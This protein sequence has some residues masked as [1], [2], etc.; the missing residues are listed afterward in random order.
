VTDPHLSAAQAT[1]AG[2][3][4]AATAL[5]VGELASAVLDLA[6]SP[7]LGVGGRFVDSFAASLKE[8]AV[9]LF[10]TNDKPALVIGTVVSTILLGAA[11][12]AAARRRRWAPWPVFSAF[13]VVGALAQTH[14]PRVSGAGPWVVALLSASAGIATL[15]VLLRAASAPTGDRPGAATSGTATGGTAV[16]GDLLVG[17]RRRFL[18]GA[19]T[20]AVGA[21]VMAA[22]GRAMS[23]VDVVA[24]AARQFRLPTPTRR[25]PVADAELGLVG[26]SPVITPT[27]DF[28]RIDTALS[29][30]QVDPSWWTL[31]IDG[32]VREPFELTFDELLALPSVEEPVTLQ[33]VSNE[34]GGSLVGTAR[35]QGVPL[36]HLLE[37]AGV[38]P[39]AEQVFSRSVDGW[40][41]GFPIEA[42]DDGRVALVA[43][44]MNGELLPVAHGFPARLVVSGLYGYVS[45]TKWVES[46]EL[47]TWEGED[48]YWVPRGWS[49]R[50]PA[51]LTSRID[52]PRHRSTVAAG[53]VTVAGVAWLPA[54]GIEAVEVSVDGGPWRS[55]ELAPAISEHTWVQWRQVID[56]AP[57]DHRLRV[58][59]VDA[60]GAVQT[61]TR[62]DPAPDGATGL[63]QVRV[64][65]VSS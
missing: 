41:S 54:T 25:R 48:G 57:G 33:C 23:R 62:T 39:E 22:A 42:V 3:L 29:S 64:Q 61:A 27:A 4:A 10:G 18:V 8:L 14:D 30:P 11:M 13:A 43:Y 5:A 63:H 20:A 58:R 59:A 28:Y 46:I 47:T 38:R 7:V 44:A 9:A 36:A 26:L 35:W 53:P 2:A 1:V 32:L 56:L 16:P 49:K 50:G 51:K 15:E 12:G 37:R 55:T 34:V 65:A 21:V 24:E 40:T 60:T 6:V 52:V 31:R 45:A 19:T 17:S